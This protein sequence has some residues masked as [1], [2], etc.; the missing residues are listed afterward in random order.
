VHED[1]IRHLRYPILQSVIRYL[2]RI[3]EIPKD[4]SDY[5]ELAEALYNPLYDSE[6]DPVPMIF[7]ILRKHKFRFNKQNLT[8]DLSSYSDIKIFWRHV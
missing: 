8:F 2:S 7:Q 5:P 3:G 1:I 4:L 6:I